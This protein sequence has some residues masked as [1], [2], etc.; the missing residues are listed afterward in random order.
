[1]CE[2]KLQ[3]VQD[4][5]SGQAPLLVMVHSWPALIKIGN[6]LSELSKCAHQAWGIARGENDP[7]TTLSKFRA[8]VYAVADYCGNT[9]AFSS[10]KGA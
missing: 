8:W 1:M 3:F 2:S 6:V 4:S 7:I 9:H 5:F 10:C